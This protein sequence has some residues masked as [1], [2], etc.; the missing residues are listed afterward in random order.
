MTLRRWRD[1]VTF[2]VTR[3]G[4]RGRSG[5]FAY[6]FPCTWGWIAACW[7]NEW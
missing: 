6:T 2:G 1:V 3:E 4:E 5:S 7:W